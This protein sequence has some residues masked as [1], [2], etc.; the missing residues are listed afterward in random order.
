MI[1]LVGGANCGTSASTKPRLSMR[2][3]GEKPRTSLPSANITQQRSLSS[4]IT[5]HTAP[6]GPSCFNQKGK[7]RVDLAVGQQT[8]KERNGMKQMNKRALSL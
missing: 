8:T 2:L 4:T 5:Q 6:T 7:G 3:M 1:P